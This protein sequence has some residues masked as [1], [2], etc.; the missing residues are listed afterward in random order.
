MQTSFK[1]RCPS[2][3]LGKDLYAGGICCDKIIAAEYIQKGGTEPV[4]YQEDILVSTRVCFES[5]KHLAG[6]CG[7]VKG[8]RAIR[9]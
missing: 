1:K 5:V 7:P 9:E 3:C 4:I 6:A 8:D 2:R